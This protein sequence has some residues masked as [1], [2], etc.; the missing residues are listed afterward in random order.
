[1]GA[2]AKSVLLKV[3]RIVDSNVY[4]LKKIR[5]SK[6][7]QKRDLLR[8][9]KLLFRVKATNDVISFTSK[10]RFIRDLFFDRQQKNFSW[11]T[12]SGERAHCLIE[13]PVFHIDRCPITLTF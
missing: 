1:M 5:F 3:L 12:L 13:K 6:L 7:R 4:N 10:N 2:I 9:I 8:E 11:D